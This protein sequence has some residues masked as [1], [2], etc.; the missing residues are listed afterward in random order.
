MSV[1]YE[2]LP[3]YS[4]KR[5]AILVNDGL[6]ELSVDSISS[7]D[8]ITTV[9]NDGHLSDRKSINLPD[10]FIDMPYLSDADRADIE[11]GIAQDVD[12]IAMS[13]VRSVEDVR[14]VKRLLNEH[15]A[16]N[17]QL[18]AKIETVRAWRT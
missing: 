15:D 9:M 16:N 2:D 8:I 1:T 14:I 12:Y 17:I 6:I 11:F 7:T 5:R 3:K 13:F 4:Q 18:I 10:T